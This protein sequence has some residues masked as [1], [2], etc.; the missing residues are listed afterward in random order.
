MFLAAEQLLAA[1]RFSAAEQLLAA[2]RRQVVARGASPWKRTPSESA[3]EGR[4]GQHAHS[5]NFSGVSV[6][7]CDVDFAASLSAAG[8]RLVPGRPGLVFAGI[9]R[10]LVGRATGRSFAGFEADKTGF[11]AGP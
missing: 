6:A 11:P 9:T 2:E 10:V 1:E 7:G 3:L 4:Q 8:V 5:G